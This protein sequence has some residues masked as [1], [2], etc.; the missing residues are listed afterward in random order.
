MEIAVLQSAISCGCGI[1]EQGDRCCVQTPQT[2]GTKLLL[3][4]GAKAVAVTGQKQICG[5][6]H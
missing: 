3:N 6:S 5:Y 2:A 1:R 4:E